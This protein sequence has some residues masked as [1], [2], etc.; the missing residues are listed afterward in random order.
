MTRRHSLGILLLGTAC[1]PLA[2]ACGLGEG[3]LGGSAIDSTDN[4]VGAAENASDDAHADALSEL[5]ATADAPRPDATRD[6]DG[7]SEGNDGGHDSEAKAD[8]EVGIDVEAGTNVEAG[9]D[10]E[11]DADVEVG[12]DAGGALDAQDDREAGATD[13]SGDSSCAS[14]CVDS[15]PDGQTPDAGTTCDFTGTWGSRL[16]IDVSWT[17]QGITGIILS[18]GSGAITQWL[19]S[20]RV[21]NGSS[22]TESVVVCGIHLPDFQSTALAGNEV[23]GVGFPD[24]LFDNAYIPAFAV[25]SSFSGTAP[26]STYGTAASAVLLGLTLSSPTSTPWPATVTTEVDMDQ[27][28][29]PGVTA[30]TLQGNGYSYPPV[31]ILK[32]SRADKLYLAIRQVTKLSAT[33]SDCDHLTGTISIPTITDP[34]SGASKAGIDSHVIGCEISGTSTSCNS[35]QTSFVDNTQPVFTPNGGSSFTSVRLPQG[36]SCATV[37]QA[38]P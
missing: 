15:G 6:A 3:G 12:P 38:L 37:R 18:P 1:A 35:T 10:V 16:V 33:A 27:D 22:F 36:S 9:A 8:V 29:K 20:T 25:N 5:D 32:S 30:N 13:G 14:G 17:P 11:I 24:S 19:E 21:K 2:A 31:D 23:Y 7:G 4:E 28:G 34:S 26:G